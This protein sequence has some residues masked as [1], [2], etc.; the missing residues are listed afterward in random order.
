MPVKLA[1]LVALTLACASPS[2]TALSSHGSPYLLVVNN[3]PY[4]ARVHG[5]TGLI[6][7]VEPNQQR[8]FRLAGI[9]TGAIWLW[10]E[11]NAYERVQT[12]DF[13]LWGSPGWSWTLTTAYR[14]DV[15]VVR[16]LPC[17]ESASY[18]R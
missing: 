9:S 7:T 5:P 14:S 8:C 3:S 10:A 16:A 2:R 17:R 6:G 4:A 1:C 11:F 13:D 18:E 12:L 15:F